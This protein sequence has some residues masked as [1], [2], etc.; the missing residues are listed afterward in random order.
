MNPNAALPFSVAH[1]GFQTVPGR[2]QKV[3]RLIRDL[4]LTKLVTGYRG[5]IGNTL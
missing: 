3:I 1:E 2:N 4:Q 5:N